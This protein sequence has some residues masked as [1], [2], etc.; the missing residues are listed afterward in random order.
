MT[1]GLIEALVAAVAFG[2]AALLQAVAARREGSGGALDVR[3]LVRMLR[4]WAF[5]GAIVLNLVGFALHFSALRTLPLF[6]AQS[7]ISSSVVV[8]ALLSSRVLKAPL[9]RAEYGAVGAVVVGLVLVAAAAGDTGSD[10]T[11]VR[12][13]LGLLVA[14]AAVVV[15][16]LA[17]GRVRG[18][19]GALVLGGVAGV[20]F[21]LVSISARVLPSF[22]PASALGDPATYA[23]VVSGVTAFMLYSAA[24]QRGSA[25]SA[26]AAMVL[27]QTAVPS[28]VGVLLLGDAIR[29]GYL[30]VLLVGVVAAAGGAVALAR[31]DPASLGVEPAGATESEKV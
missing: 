22:A 17:A 9:H 27:G 25:L 31:F 24:F 7:I 11:S 4:D 26:T 15:A 19:V 1:F 14:M 2:V 13:R 28:V 5:V 6:L 20:G 12:W 10:E 23:L 18:A 29:D 21:A 16:G 30:A 3:L 8:T